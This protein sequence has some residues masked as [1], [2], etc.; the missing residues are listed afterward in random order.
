MDSEAS[1]LLIESWIHYSMAFI[2]KCSKEEI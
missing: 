2:K 1:Y